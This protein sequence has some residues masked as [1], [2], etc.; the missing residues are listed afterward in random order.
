MFLPLLK[1][2]ERKHER[3]IAVGETISIKELDRLKRNAGEAYTVRNVGIY[4]QVEVLEFV[5]REFVS[6]SR[7]D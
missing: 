5:P 2:A 4:D 7:Q 1:E 6:T 3:F